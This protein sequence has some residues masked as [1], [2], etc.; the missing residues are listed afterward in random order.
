ML[1]YGMPS[2]VSIDSTVG[3]PLEFVVILL[4]M[5]ITMGSSNEGKTLYMPEERA[6][7]SLIG[8]IYG[9]GLLQRSTLWGRN[10]I[11]H[12]GPYGLYSF[13]WYNTGHAEFQGD[14]ELRSGYQHYHVAHSCEW[15]RRLYCLLFSIL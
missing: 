8:C 4:Y 14:K 10:M 2:T 5:I 6:G 13:R 1:H 9:Y 3:C 7:I 11:L 15:V 12:V